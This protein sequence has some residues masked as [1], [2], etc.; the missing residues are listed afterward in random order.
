MQDD[1]PSVDQLPVELTRGGMLIQYENS[2][3]DQANT[4]ESEGILDQVYTLM[5]NGTPIGQ[6]AKALIMTHD[7]LK[8][9][10]KSSPS[11]QRRYNIART[12]ALA[13][14]SLDTLALFKGHTFMLKEE[15]AAA[16][17]HVNMVGVAS[18]AL[19]REENEEGGSKIVVNTQINYGS[20]MDAPPLPDDLK[21]VL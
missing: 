17:H 19:G 5:A 8:N 21:K 2:F 12:S 13:D 6:L 4:L 20:G 15:A 3:T 16:K 11:R 7:R 9:I 1:L 10:L 18:N 14:G